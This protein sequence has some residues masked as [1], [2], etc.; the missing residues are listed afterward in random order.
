M[1]DGEGVHRRVVFSV[2]QVEIGRFKDDVRWVAD[3]FGV[4]AGEVKV[5]DEYARR[6]ISY[7]IVNGTMPYARGGLVFVAN[8]RD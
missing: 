1:L 7:A 6:N 4:N 5:F 2:F 8:F 3:L